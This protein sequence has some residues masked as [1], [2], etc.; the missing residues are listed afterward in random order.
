MFEEKSIRE[1]LSAATPGSPVVIGV[2]SQDA[3]SVSILDR[4]RGFS[5]KFRELSEGVHSDAVEVTG[6]SLFTKPS[7]RKAAVNILVRIPASTEYVDVQVTAQNMLEKTPNLIGIFCSN[8]GTVTG[9][10]AGT[11]DGKDLDRENGIYKHI[12]VIGFDAGITQ[13]QA[14]RKRYIHGSITQDPYRIGYLAVELAY[15]AIKG[16]SVAPLVDTGCK[17]YDYTNIDNQDIA[18]LVYD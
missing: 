15:K 13:K 16:E 4:T 8:E 17:F 12:T 9:L 5:D 3:V 11:D 7:A 6:H 14:V 1:R 2:L 10:L 18:Q